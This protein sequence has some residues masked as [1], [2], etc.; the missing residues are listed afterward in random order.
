MV[1]RQC[2]LS[3][4]LILLVAADAGCASIFAQAGSAGGQIGK[5][6]KSVSGGDDGAARQPQHGRSSSAPGEAKPSGVTAADLAG[7]WDWSA[8]C[9]L[10]GPWKGG[11]NLSETSATGFVGEMTKG[12]QGS[13]KGTVHGNRMS[14]RRV[15]LVLVQ[16]WSGSLS[17]SGSS[18]KWK[19]SLTG[20]EDCTFTATRN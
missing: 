8:N 20:N 4:L 3:L 6:G 11:F 1:T 12:H 7:N 9:N 10:S 13:L 17:R 2:F 16:F 18:W 14:F 15:W 5:Q 19:G